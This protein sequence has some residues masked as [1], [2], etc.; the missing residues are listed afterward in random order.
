MLEFWGYCFE[1]RSSLGEEVLQAL[2][3]KVDEFDRL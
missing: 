1:L 2:V 3:D